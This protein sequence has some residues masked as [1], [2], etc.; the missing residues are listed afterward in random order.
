MPKM[1]SLGEEN[2][3]KMEYYNRKEKRKKYSS[4]P[5]WKTCDKPVETG[6]L[7]PEL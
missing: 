2:H 3:S 6:C 5:K 7:K 4:Y 1:N